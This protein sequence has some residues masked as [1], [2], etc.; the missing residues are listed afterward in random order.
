MSINNI[1]GLLGNVLLN[2]LQ[3]TNQK[4]ATAFERLSTGLKI[5]R[6]SDDA[7]GMAMATR[8][9]SQER[10]LAMAERNAQTGISV[11]QTAE[12]HLEST[13]S[14]IE[15]IRE[16]SVQAANGTLNESDRAAI[17]QEID[18]LKENIDTTLSN[19]EFNSK[20]LFGGQTERFQIGTDAGSIMEVKFENLSTESLG[21]NDIDVTSQAGAEAAIT[22]S[23]DA[24]NKVLGFRT[25]LGASQNRLESALSSLSQTRLDTAS[26]LSLI[27]DANMAEEALN[28]SAATTRLQSQLM[29]V[30]QINKINRD[31]VPLLLGE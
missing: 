15:R 17:Q 19:A 30:G 28:L 13:T 27:R 5:N 29:L 16:L 21:L 9:E 24:L 22:Q 31:A 26:S 8:L 3:Q 7:A 14:D 20:K 11:V 10:G 25:D 1:S 18:Q 2:E 12:G 4:V 23:D 6:A